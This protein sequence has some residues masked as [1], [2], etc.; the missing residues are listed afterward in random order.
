MKLQDKVCVI[1]GGGSGI[2]RAAA[3]LFAKEGASVVIA[4]VSEAAGRAAAEA[5]GAPAMAVPT[6]VSDEGSVERLFSAVMT[7]HG[8]IDVLVNNAGYGHRANITDTTLA[9]WN[10][11]FAVNVTG[12][13]LGCKYGIERMREGGGGVIV[14][15]ASVA[16][17]VGVHERAAYCATK[18]A[19]V[20]M[21]RAMALDHVGENIR[22]NAVAPSTI[23]SPY[24]ERIFA[25]APDPAALR[26]EYENRQPMGR[27]GTP[28]EIAEGILWLA[29]GAASFVTG[30]I[31]TLD[32]G[33]L[34]Q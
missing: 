21:T 24:F 28:E 4:D 34:A 19:V 12:V 14:N 3:A 9:D 23:D 6:D 26:R 15:T 11:L 33:M 32:G 8:R 25:E 17:L 2:G 7:A 13:Y 22:I 5:L 31:M 27:M 10:R 18:G 29:S 16:G 20:A 30:S 1:T